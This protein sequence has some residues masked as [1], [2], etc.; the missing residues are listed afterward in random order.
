MRPHMARAVLATQ[1]SSRSGKAKRRL[2]MTFSCWRTHGPNVRPTALPKAEARSTDSR[3]ASELISRNRLAS[4]WRNKR[5]EYVDTK[6]TRRSGLAKYSLAIEI[7]GL[8]ADDLTS[9]PDAYGLSIP[10]GPIQAL[11]RPVHDVAR[12]SGLA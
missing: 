5:S 8:T 12:R 1:A 7:Q 10:G 3:S 4:S 2:R 9:L 11:P 6:A